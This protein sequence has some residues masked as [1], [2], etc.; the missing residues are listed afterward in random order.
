MHSLA[1]S[2]LS[3][4]RRDELLQAGDRV[5]IAVSGGIDSVALLCLL[6]ELRHEL[7]IVLSVIHFNHKLRGA[8]SDADQVFVEGSAR[9]HGLEFYCKSDDA[10]ELASHQHSG[11]EAAARELRY[12]FFQRLLG[13]DEPE[14]TQEPPLNKIATGHT[15]D[16]QAETVLMRLIRGTGLRGLGG[17]H[18]RIVVEDE[19]GN[20]H[21]EIVRPLLGVRRQELEKYLNDLKQPW[22]EDS[23]NRST[24][25]LRNQLRAILA[26]DP[27]LRQSFLQLGKTCRQLKRWLAQTAPH[28]PDS[29]PAASLALLPPPVARHSA[30]RK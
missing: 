29:F 30:A 16:D 21:G 13:A 28:L 9:E 17:I 24:K 4:I 26:D 20:G 14:S 15:L 7:G 11:L 10:A 5:G 2:V 19:D 18:P 1:E 6:L 22:R 8:D 3:L 23:S 25:Y 27:A 12:G